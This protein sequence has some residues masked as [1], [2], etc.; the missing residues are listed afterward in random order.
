TTEYEFT[1]PPRGMCTFRRFED[2]NLVQRGKWQIKGRNLELWDSSFDKKLREK[3]FWLENEFNADGSREEY[4]LEFLKGA[5]S[6]DRRFYRTTAHPRACPY[7]YVKQNGSYQY[8][9]EILRNVM[10]KSQQTVQSLELENGLCAKDT[11]RVKISE[12]KPET[13]YLDNVQL[14]AGNQSIQPGR[15]QTDA[16]DICRDDQ[17]FKKLSRGDTLELEFDLSDVKNCG[18]LK[19]RADGYYVPHED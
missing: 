13:T 2:G 16:G 15:C 8:K 7:V 19:L 9:G 3:W 5:G 14:Q 17:V 12:E 18:D 1:C 10:G 4:V 6:V 11:L